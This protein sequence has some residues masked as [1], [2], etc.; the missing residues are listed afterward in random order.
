[1]NAPFPKHG[2]RVAVVGSGIAGLSTAWLLSQSGRH[3]VL[4]ESESRLGGHSNTVDVTVDGM[5]HPVDTGFLVYNERTYPNLIAL[6]DW[7]GVP[8][9][10]TEMS[11][12]VSL[13][14]PDLEWAGSSL[15]TVFGQSKNLVRPAF[16]RM[17]TDI[18]RFNRESSAWLA[19]PDRARGL[20]L[21]AFLIRG[22]YSDEFTHWYLLPMAGA[23]WSCPAAQML[24]YPLETFLR[25]CRNH[26]LLQIFNRPS[27]RTVKGGSRVYV[28]RLAEGIAEIRRRTPVEGVLR[29]PEHIMLRTADGVEMFDAVV[30]ATHADTTLKILGDSATLDERS[31]LLA[32]PY[33]PN[34]AVLHTDPAL[35]PRHQNLWAAWNYLGGRVVP[36]TAESDPVAVSYLINRLQPLPFRTP[37]VVTLNPTRE[38]DPATVFA[39]FDYAHP[40]FDMSG[41]AAQRRL[42]ELQGRNRTWFAGAWTGYGFHEDGLKS[43]IAVARA[44]G[45]EVPW[46]G[47]MVREAV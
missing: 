42:P 19:H 44:M 33:Q 40:V 23:I 10:E 1:M 46:R 32:I 43:G 35:L 15:A 18:L 34:R 12:S 24:D 47:A 39:E 11:F 26:G 2:G 6:F 8:S 3:A 7:L 36:G 25:F 21:R 37:V 30:F 13:R 31:A 41:I 5:T 14:E 27:W 17:L 16:W 28:E 38:P 22:G 9:V 45:A 4:F 29:T 20:D